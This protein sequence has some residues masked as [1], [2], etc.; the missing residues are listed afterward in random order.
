MYRPPPALIQARLDRKVC[1]WC[2]SHPVID[3]PYICADCQRHLADDELR[4]RQNHHPEQ[5]LFPPKE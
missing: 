1:I 4:R 2:G 5:S 3:W